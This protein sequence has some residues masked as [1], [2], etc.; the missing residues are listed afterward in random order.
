[1]IEALRR[2]VW[3][4]SAEIGERAGLRGDGLERARD[5]I[6]R[7]FEAGVPIAFGSDTI[8]PHHLAAKEFSRMVG[9]G[10]SP[11]RAIQAATINAARVLGI[12]DQVGTLEA[13]KVADI[14]AVPGN[15]VERIQ[16]LEEV[17][18]V[19]KRGLVIEAPGH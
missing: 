1:M 14:I 2:H 7:A 18:F 12:E 3:A 6:G 13:G 9:L 15:P 17:P 16:L 11:T 5:Y 10:L 4:L 8:F 19:M